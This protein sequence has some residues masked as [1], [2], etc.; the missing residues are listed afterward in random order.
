M[1]NQHH[2]HFF[3]FTSVFTCRFFV[4]FYFF[5]GFCRW[6]DLSTRRL[7][8]GTWRPGSAC[9]RWRRTRSLWRLP[10]STPMAPGWC[11]AARTASCEP[12]VH[13]KNQNTW[14]L[15]L[16]AVPY[17]C[18]CCSPSCLLQTR[19]VRLIRRRPNWL[20][21]RLRKL[22]RSRVLHIPRREFSYIC[23]SIV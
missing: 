18:V 11:R 10:L 9:A 22:M 12:L 21:G 6:A 17:I 5:F 19:R 16:G 23:T 13:Y 7:R 2:F 4:A 3:V 15:V 1:N 14:Y 20:R 8:F